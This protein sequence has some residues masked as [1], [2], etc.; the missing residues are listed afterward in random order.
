MFSAGRGVSSGQNVTNN[1]PPLLFHEVHGGNIMISRD[2]TVA[3]RIESF[4]KGVAFS[5]RPVK[6]AEKVIFINNFFRS[7]LSNLKESML[8]ITKKIFISFYY[9]KS[10]MSN[11]KP[12]RI[13]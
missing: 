12:Y 6:I 8:C 11:F 3:R 13:M 4:C 9:Y 7:N 2:G 5:D 1:L 10:I